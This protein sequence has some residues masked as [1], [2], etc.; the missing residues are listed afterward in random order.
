MKDNLV[1]LAPTIERELHESENRRA[2]RQAEE[3]LRGSQLYTRLLMESNIDALMTTDPTGVITDVNQQMES[4]S[5]RTLDQL[6][7]TP[8]KQPFTHPQRAADGI[9]SV[10]HS[11]P[12]T[13]SPLTPLSNP[14]P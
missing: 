12:I 2:R 1:R 11:A 7:G 13:T 8:F 3:Q 4:L 5:G 10:F 6:I 9:P 14:P